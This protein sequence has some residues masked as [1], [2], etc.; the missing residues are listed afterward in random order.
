MPAEVKSGCARC[1]LLA[2]AF[3]GFGVLPAAEVATFHS[4]QYGYTLNYPSDWFKNSL[5]P[6]TGLFDIIN[7]P[8]SR[9]AHAVFLP[10]TGA[11]ITVT[12][13]EAR[14]GPTDP[15]SSA[16]REVPHTLEEWIAIATRGEEVELR[17][18][19][20]IGGRPP[21]IEIRMKAADGLEVLDW[22]FSLRGRLFN[23]RLLCW[24]G[25]SEFEGLR[26]VLEQIVLTLEAEFR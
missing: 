7:F 8:P 17:R 2:V 6:S 1:L 23:A 13:I 4:D 26:R 18:D 19:L 9:A 11:E 12:P 25:N 15:R 16:R 3:S 21:V 22:Y 5:A 14:Q 24:V 20:T 10:P